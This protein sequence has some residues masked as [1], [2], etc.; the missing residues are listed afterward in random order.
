M[1]IRNSKWRRK[2]LP[3]WLSPPTVTQAPKAEVIGIIVP[4]KN[5]PNSAK[6]LLTQN[7][8]E[9]GT[10]RASRLKVGKVDPRL[11]VKAAKLSKFPERVK[12]I[13]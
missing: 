9:K 1:G 8:V 11:G 7:F 12:A 2:I 4:V 10:Y 3:A 13:Y 5:N 6:E